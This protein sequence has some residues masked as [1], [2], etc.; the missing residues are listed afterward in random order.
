MAL[1][2]KRAKFVRVCAFFSLVWVC[3]GLIY[4]CK[5][6]LHIFVIL[7]AKEGARVRRLAPHIR[8]PC[9]RPAHVPIVVT[10]CSCPHSRYLVRTFS[11]EYTLIQGWG[12]SLPPSSSYRFFKF[13]LHFLNTLHSFYNQ[14]LNISS[15]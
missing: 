4:V 9:H 6:L 1:A 5:C 13:Y 7:R 3:V 15:I 10:L 11:V 8:G 12:L 2:I 14:N